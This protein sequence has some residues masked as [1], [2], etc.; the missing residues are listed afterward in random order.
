MILAIVEIK[1]Y[2][3]GAHS[4]LALKGPGEI[5]YISLKLN[6][7]NIDQALRSTILK[8]TFDGTQ[9][10]WCPVGD[11]FGSGFG[12]NKYQGR[13]RAILDD[14]SMNCAWPMPFN[15]KCEFVLENIG[16]Q[17]V[18]IELG[19]FVVKYDD[20]LSSNFV[21]YMDQQFRDNILYFHCA[22]QQF[23]K[24][25]TI[26]ADGTDLNWIDIKGEGKYVGDSLTLYNGADAWWGEG[27]EKN[28]Y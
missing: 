13:Y 24:I 19:E 9:T 10:V 28:L 7:K 25:K 5:R 17:D 15:K 2:I 16:D 21:C 22:W 8:I 27:D 23:S 18:N 14:E 12:L 11:F 3:P 1:F 26:K 4:A 6:A 20:P